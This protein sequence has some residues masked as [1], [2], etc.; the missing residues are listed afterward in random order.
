MSDETRLEAAR[1]REERTMLSRCRITRETLEE[2]TDTGIIDMT[3]QDPTD[4]LVWEGPCGLV[5]NSSAVFERSV[6]GVDLAVQ[7]L[8]LKLPVR[9]LGVRVDDVATITDGGPDPALTD[10]QFRIADVP[11]RTRATAR[12]FPVEHRGRG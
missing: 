5:S 2:S 9:A 3:D 6:E 8:L 12:R 4:D 10:E 11:F 1:R 7:Q